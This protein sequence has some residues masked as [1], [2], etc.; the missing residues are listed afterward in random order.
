FAD[1]A[2]YTHRYD[3]TGV[4]YRSTRTRREDWLATTDYFFRYD[5]GVT[6]VFPK[7]WLGRL[8]LGR[9]VRSTQLLSA[10]EKLTFLL[11]DQKP[12]I[13]LD[14]FVPFS[15]APEFFDWY[16][17]AIGFFPLW[18]VPY[19]VPRRYEWLSERFVRQMT[20]D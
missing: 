16:R 19:R 20:D 13:I 8:L 3:W 5:H 18:V 17:K 7:S 15:R 6:N 2:P 4:Y 14:V 10:A 9:F 12:T 1:E 11:D